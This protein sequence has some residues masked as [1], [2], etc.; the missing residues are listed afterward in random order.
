MRMKSKI[1][2][3]LFLIL[4]QLV[5]CRSDVMLHGKWTYI[6]N[7]QERAE[8]W[9]EENRAMHI[10]ET[11]YNIDFYKYLIQ[12][13]SLVLIDITGT[14][15]VTAFAI[16]QDENDNL[17]LVNRFVQMELTRFNKDAHFDT[18]AVAVKNTPVQNK[19]F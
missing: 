2:I 13:D 17:T 6:N 5:G 16:S 14:N 3:V 4:I 10:D 1:S 18:T 19:I 7:Q 8:F 15:K 11:S 12:Q 9:F